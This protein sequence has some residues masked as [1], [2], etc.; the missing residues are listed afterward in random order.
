MDGISIPG[1]FPAS[2]HSW[3]GLQLP[4]AEGKLLPSFPGVWKCLTPIGNANGS[5]AQTW[6]GFGNTTFPQDFTLLR[7]SL[8]DPS[9]SKSFKSLENKP[10]EEKGLSLLL[11]GAP[12][13]RDMRE[14]HKIPFNFAASA[15]I[16]APAPHSLTSRTIPALSADGNGQ[17]VT[18]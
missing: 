18:D 7:S 15:E 6:A 16:P 1:P 10:N 14:H 11:K 4:C 13:Q 3:A 12:R 2:H 17:A 9:T 8:P 5:K